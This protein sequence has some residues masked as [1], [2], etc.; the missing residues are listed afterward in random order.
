MVSGFMEC[1]MLGVGEKDYIVDGGYEVLYMYSCNCDGLIILEW[2]LISGEF[3]VMYMVDI[4]D[5]VGNLV[6][7]YVNMI[8][9]SVMIVYGM[10]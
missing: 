9:M 6:L 4:E 1:V 8:E 10:L 7:D 2:L 5:S 3:G